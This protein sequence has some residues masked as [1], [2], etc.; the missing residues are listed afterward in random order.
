MRSRAAPA[1]VN[2]LWVAGQL[3]AWHRFKRAARQPQE[4][5]SDRLRRYVRANRDTEFGRQ[6]RFASIRS[7]DDYR[8]R[9]SIRTYDEMEPFIHRISR[10]EPN[11][12]TAEA[13]ERL[14]PSSGSTRAAKLIPFTP[15]L[16]REF[17]AA[18]GAWVVDMFSQTPRALAGRAYWSISPATAAV[19]DDAASSVPIGFEDDAMYLGLASR[20]LA[21]AVLAVPPEIRFIS[22]GAFT[23]ATMVFLLRARELRIVSVWHPSFFERLL[24]TWARHADALLRDVHDGTLRPPDSD[25]Q[26]PVLVR[27]ARTLTPRPHIAKELRRGA[28]DD[29][30]GLWPHLQSVSC[31]ADGASAGPAASLARRLGAVTV[32]PKGLLATEGIVTIPFGGRHPL[33]VTSHFLEFATDDGRV[34]DAHELQPGREY[35]VVLTTG[36]GLYRYRLGDRVRVDGFVDAAPSLRLVG[37]DDRVSDLFGEKLSE[38][39][40]GSVLASIFHAAPRFAML[41]PEET[42]GGVAYTLFVDRECSRR[43]EDLA[44]RLEH[45]LRRNPHYAWCVD[46]GQLQRARIV[47]VGPAATQVYLDERVARGQR[48]GDVKP[49]R[50]DTGMDWGRVLPRVTAGDPV[51]C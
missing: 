8:E 22:P 33:A 47:S 35:G 21:R 17:T 30:R 9:V 36:G 16:R 40:V 5:Q 20:T 37:R 7:V 18:V 2:T 32:A 44:R 10:G 4:A 3:G 1:V 46:V 14:V 49:T 48:L 45:E 42:P 15:A 13:V 23:Y 19:P 29:I 11:V 31:W 34:H 28:A 43:H 38:G 50:L 27:L 26:D 6:H 41:A 51:P 24:D 25:Q 39:F 12:L